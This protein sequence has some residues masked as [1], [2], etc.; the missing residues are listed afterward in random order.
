MTADLAIVGGNLAVELSITN[1]GV[2]PFYYNWPVEMSLLD[3]KGSLGTTWTTDWKL[4]RVQPDE[5]PVRWQCHAHLAALRPGTYRVLLRVPNPMAGGR[6]LRFANLAQD[7]D[8][9][10]WLTLGA[11]EPRRE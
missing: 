5:A 3:S 9:P 6:P 4:T 10:G 2:A 11:A 7:R 8:L 1:H